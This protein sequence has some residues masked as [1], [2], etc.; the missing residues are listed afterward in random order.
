MFVFSILFMV[1]KVKSPRSPGIFQ[2]YFI[3]VHSTSKACKEMEGCVNYDADLVC[4]VVSYPGLVKTDVQ[5]KTYVYIPFGPEY[6]NT[7]K[8]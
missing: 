8:P 1:R 3:D 7:D 6:V 2:C 4:T 5:I